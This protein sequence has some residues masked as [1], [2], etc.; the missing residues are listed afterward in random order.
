[1]AMI[2]VGIQEGVKIAGVSLTEN[3]DVELSLTQ[4]AEVDALAALTGDGNLSGPDASNVRVFSLK[5][6]AYGTKIEGKKLVEAIN[7]YKAFYNEI[8]VQYFPSTEIS[9]SGMFE[10][11]DVKVGSDIERLSSS[12]VTRVGKNIVTYFANKMQEADL[13]KENR[14]KFL[15]QS[16]GKNF[17]SLKPEMFT[18]FGKEQASGFRRTWT[19]PFIESMDIPK[20]ASKLKYDN[21]DKGLDKDGNKV[22]WDKTSPDAVQ[23]DTPSSNP[24]GGSGLPF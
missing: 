12:D 15:R 22:S 2:K 17:I 24:T 20:D 6:E 23:A 11:T 4:G 10:G 19:V 13:T 16:E 5:D 7:A 3:N 21:F 14:I 1:M 18:K 8:L 9:W